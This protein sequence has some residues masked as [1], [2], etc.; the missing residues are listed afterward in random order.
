MEILCIVGAARP[1]VDCGRRVGAQRQGAT[2][3]RRA[4]A[5]AREQGLRRHALLDPFDKSAKRIG[6]NRTGAAGG[7]EVDT[8]VSDTGRAEQTIK[9]LQIAEIR[10][11]E[12]AIACRH[13]AVIV[14]HATRVDELVISAHKGEQLAAML[15]NS[16]SGFNVSVTS[17]MFLDP[18][19]AT[20]GYPESGTFVQSKLRSCSSQ[21][22]WVTPNAK[23]AGPSRM[24]KSLPRSS[25]NQILLSRTLRG[26]SQILST[27]VASAAVRQ[28]DA[29]AVGRP[30]ML[31]VALNLHVRGSSM[32]PSTTPSAASQAWIADFWTWTS[33]A[34]SIAAPVNCFMAI[35]P[36]ICAVW[37]RLQ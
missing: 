36:H 24:K 16:S 19:C 14:N 30:Q 7:P 3:R 29:G 20:C 15:L 12:P 28:A 21:W 23:G 32:M 8:A 6:R 34:G 33:L 35:W 2:S 11:T 18:S 25:P 37:N 9:A 10:L 27:A 17:A 4:C 22:N 26:P 1:I 5:T 31:A 13:L